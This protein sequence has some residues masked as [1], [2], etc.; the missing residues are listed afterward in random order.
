MADVYCYKDREENRT[1]GFKSLF[2]REVDSLYKV[3]RDT[4]NRYLGLERDITAYQIEK[5]P[6]NYTDWNT[7]ENLNP[8]E[9]CVTNRGRV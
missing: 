7:V 9:Y 5:M 1:F 8:Q 2:E 6:Y 4:Q 3:L